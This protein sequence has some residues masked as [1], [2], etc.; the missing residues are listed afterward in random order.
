MS[1]GFMSSTATKSSEGVMTSAERHGRKVARAQAALAD[2]QR[3]LVWQ[4]SEGYTTQA[5]YSK[6]TIAKLEKQLAKLV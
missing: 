2:A 3:V 5:E 6:Q 4:E 1:K